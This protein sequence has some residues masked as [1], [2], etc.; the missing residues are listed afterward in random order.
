MKRIKVLLSQ[1]QFEVLDE[2]LGEF[3][4]KEADENYNSKEMKFA[5][6]LSKKLWKAWRVAQNG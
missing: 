4:M 5:G 6:E 1:K 3:I 2:V